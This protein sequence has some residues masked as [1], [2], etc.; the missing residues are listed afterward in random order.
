MSLGS[1]PKLMN[2][3][4]ADTLGGSTREIIGTMGIGIAKA[5]CQVPVSG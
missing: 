2:E 3:I 5:L 4:P 1:I